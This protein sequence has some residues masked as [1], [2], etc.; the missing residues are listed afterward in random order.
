MRV[1]KTFSQYG[2]LMGSGACVAA[3][4]TICACKFFSKK[5]VESISEL[6]LHSI[7]NLFFVTFYNC[8]G[9]LFMII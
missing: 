6:S 2:N 1:I 9:M 3:T 4:L 5:I 7:F 8:H